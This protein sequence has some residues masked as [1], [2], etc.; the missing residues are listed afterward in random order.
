MYLKHFNNPFFSPFMGYYDLMGR[1]VDS[2]GPT[3]LMIQNDN[4]AKL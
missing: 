2:Q 1:D 4:P 3:T